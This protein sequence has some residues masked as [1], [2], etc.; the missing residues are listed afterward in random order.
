MSKDTSD[1]TECIVVDAN[2]EAFFHDRVRSIMRENHVDASD[3]AVHYVVRLLTH[4]SHSER[5]FEWTSEGMTIKP[6]A[7]TYS[8]AVQARS[9]EERNWALRRLGDVALFIAG[10]FSESLNRRP[11]DVDYYISMGGSAYGSLSELPRST[12]RWQAMSAVFRELSERFAVFVD[13]L[14][15]VRTPESSDADILRLYE[16]WLRTGDPGAAR[17]LQRAGLVLHLDSRADPTFRH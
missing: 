9:D 2:I 8:E 13:V 14:S 17:K 6:L 4:F 12:H 16:T 5:F 1:R 15:G 7:I 10:M 11:V 3:E